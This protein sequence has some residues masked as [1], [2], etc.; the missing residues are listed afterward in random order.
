MSEHCASRNCNCTGHEAGGMSGASGA[1]ASSDVPS[2]RGRF[3]S[4]LG[5]RGREGPARTA[6]QSLRTPRWGAAIWIMRRMYVRAT[7]YVCVI[8]SCTRTCAPACS[9]HGPSRPSSTR[10]ETLVSSVADPGRAPARSE[11]D[12]G[13]DSGLAGAVALAAIHRVGVAA[14]VAGYA[15]AGRRL[16]HRNAARRVTAHFGHAIGVDRALVP[17]ADAAVRGAA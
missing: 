12:C 16:R 7:A 10:W 4:S 1:C 2:A 9:R 8:T 6:G 14:R 17:R 3:Q 13:A 11:D 5:R 15:L